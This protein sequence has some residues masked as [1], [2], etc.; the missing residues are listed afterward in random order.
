MLW[1]NYL[2]ITLAGL[3]TV[4]VLALMSWAGPA[5]A[6]G[7]RDRPWWDDEPR[8]WR[9]R[10][11]V[12]PEYNGDDD[13]DP[14]RDQA[15]P[16]RRWRREDRGWTRVEPER[17]NGD[18]EP[19]A[20]PR[21]MRPQEDTREDDWDRSLP[22]ADWQDPE[23]NTKAVGVDGGAR[24]YIP[25]RA[26]PVVAFAAGSTY[27]PG[28]IVIDTSARKLYFIRNSMS[29]FAYPIGVGRDGFSWT[30][31][32]KVA[33]IAD[34]PDWYPPA[35]MRKRKPELPER[36]LGG[37]RNPLG[38]KAIYLGN[39]LY[40]IHGT[41]DPKSIGRAESSGCF[42]MMNEHVLHLAT[43]VA[44]G[45]EVTVV[46]SLRDPFPRRTVQAKPR[47]APPR[48]SPRTAQDPRVRWSADPD[49]EYANP[50]DANVR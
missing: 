9:P 3:G 48:A 20:V 40:R 10:P 31:K 45:T 19:R 34:W 42:R 7:W 36:M 26:P 47:P 6:Q 32:E 37:L 27:R 17:W 25:P 5:A 38:A 30:G 23:E 4:I 49:P 43:L 21:R 12:E 46:R 41:N 29:A 33:R 8:L 14:Y 22:P 24:P 16:P 50:D 2:K 1:C 13:A 44:V 28:S 39:S 15:A 18:D 35:E 11:R